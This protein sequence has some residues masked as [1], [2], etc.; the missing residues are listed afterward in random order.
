MR[1]RSARF[2]PKLSSPAVSMQCLVA[3]HAVMTQVLLVSGGASALFRG[4]P[5]SAPRPSSRQHICPGNF[6][7]SSPRMQ[8]WRDAYANRIAPKCRC[9]GL[10][11]EH[12]A[13][14]GNSLLRVDC[15]MCVCWRPTSL[16]LNG[17]PAKHDWL[18]PF[19]P[20]LLAIC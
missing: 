19:A 7:W 11:V 13:L 6:D 2:L 16:L 9:P 1:E 18:S 20:L 15:R 8:H 5:A 10:P 17:T 4:H 12:L 14:T 3:R